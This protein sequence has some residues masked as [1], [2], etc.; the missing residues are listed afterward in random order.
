MNI[1][2]ATLKALKFPVKLLIGGKQKKPKRTEL[3][4][5][6]LKHVRNFA[7]THYSWQQRAGRKLTKKQREYYQKKRKTKQEPT[8][9]N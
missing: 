2:L 8:K 3:E 7:P 5:K 9:P 1:F 6:Q 4:Q